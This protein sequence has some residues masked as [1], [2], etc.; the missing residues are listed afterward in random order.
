MAANNEII[1]FD[2]KVKRLHQKRATKLLTGN[3]FLIKEAAEKLIDHLDGI[4]K[5]FENCLEIGARGDYLKNKIGIKKYIKTASF[6]GGSE[7]VAD[8]ELPPFK[9]NG[10]DL[11]VSLINLHWVNDLPGLLIQLRNILKKDGLL[12]VSLF[13]AGTLSELREAFLKTE[14]ELS[15]GSS[16][17]IS[18]FIDVRDGAALLQRAGFAMP[19]SDSEKIQVLYE[20]P[21]KLMHDL[22]AM[23]ETNALL[24]RNKMFSSKRFFIKLSENYKELFENEEGLIPASFEIIT[25]SGTKN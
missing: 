12:L 14:I 6:L 8:E 18:P 20:N 11:I 13:G 7:V 22:R 10:F 21:I 4:S 2:R 25:L 9:E 3:D 16:P 15:K 23:G 5:K 19:V 17:R 24:K 1:I